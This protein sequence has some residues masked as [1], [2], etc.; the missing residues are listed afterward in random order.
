MQNYKLIMQMLDKNQENL[1]KY[2]HL[3]IGILLEVGRL[4]CIGLVRIKLLEKINR[5]LVKRIYPVVVMLSE[6]I[7]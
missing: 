3:L 2:G 1:I 6:V 5:L 7:L 4:E